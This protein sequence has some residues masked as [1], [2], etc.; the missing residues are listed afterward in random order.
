[1]LKLNEYN[2]IACFYIT[3]HIV[4]I[5]NGNIEYPAQK[6]NFAVNLLLVFKLFP[7]T[8]ANINIGSLKSLH[9]FLNKC[10]MLVK[11]KR[12]CIQVFMVQTT[13]NFL[14]L[15][16]NGFF[17]PC[18]KKRWHYFGRRFCI[19]NDCLICFTIIFKT[20]IFQYSKSSLTHVTRLKVAPNMQ[21]QFV[22]NL[23]TQT[24]TLT[25]KGRVP[26]R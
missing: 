13:Q 4:S 8:A 5:S 21:T 3:Q 12:N 9:T 6:S 15:T 16:K 22:L 18:F 26:F 25:L 7:A 2:I 11:I 17:K 23:K 19:W 20:T 24:V 14:L 10:Y 1:M